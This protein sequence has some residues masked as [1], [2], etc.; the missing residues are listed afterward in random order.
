MQC[1]GEECEGRR[2]LAR[3]MHRWEDN[4]KMDLKAIEWK[5]MDRIHLVGECNK[6][7]VFVN[8]LMDFWAQ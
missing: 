4:I 6:W 8:S 7:Q 1:S 3:H 2:P 5:D